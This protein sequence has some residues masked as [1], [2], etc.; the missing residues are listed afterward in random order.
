[1]NK[2]RFMAFLGLASLQSILNLAQAQTVP[3]DAGQLLNEQRRSLPPATPERKERLVD[4]PLPE[5]QDEVGFR[6]RIERVRFSG[7]QGLVEDEALQ[8]LVADAK[9]RELSHAQMRALA[10][11]VGAALQSRGYLL[12]RAY[13]PSQ[14]LSDGEL[15][16]AILAGRLQSSPGRVQ[17]LT[18]DP[19]LGRRLGAIADA[20]LPEGPVRNDQLE[21][22]LLLINDVPGVQA[23]A[24][25][26][27]GAEPGTSRMLVRAERAR[28]WAAG[29][30]VD[31]F[32]NRYTGQWRRSAWASLNRPLDREDLLGVN[33]SHS[34][35][36]RLLG[37]NYSLGLSPKGWRANM[38]ASWMD[39]EVGGEFKPL[40]LTGSARTFSAGLSYPLLRSR[41]RNL[42]FSVDAEHRQLTDKALGQTLRDRR[43]DKFTTMLSG[44][45][46]DQWLGGGYNGMN[47]GL[48]AGRLDLDNEIDRQVD[49]ASAR[50]AGSFAK[51][52]WRVERSQSLPNLHDWGVYL[53]AS[54]QIGS[55][56]LDSSEKFLLGGPAGVRGHTV[57]EASGDTGWLLNAELRRDF[58][59]ADG[60]RGQALAFADHGHVRQHID[61]WV[62]SS[63]PWAGNEYGLS[64]A[65]LGL[66]LH[67]ERWSL[68]SA[69]AHR[70]G[71]N[72]GRS[73]T[74]TNADGRKRD[75]YL[76]L[77]LSVRI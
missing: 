68:R 24:T 72:P 13:L 10:Q 42:W 14:D 61:P 64:G 47:V 76:W 37:L 75:Q 33:V 43:V 20:A 46:W 52:L 21:R 15:E 67:S 7:A 41:E 73:A 35:G 50:T 23:R 53:A 8:A 66:N 59:I 19:A 4:A 45:A 62:G 54:G 3:P 6:A 18:S 22:A 44:N 71:D 56:N 60:L 5:A 25:L 63:T 40:D 17:V 51:L 55:K 27:K 34:D 2:T 69:W 49:A 1:M 9:G 31:N 36:S 57:G 77:Q 74:G 29:A 11:R 48:V 65:G 38:A 30:A 70:L 39:Y 58:R 12:A 28:D 26:E 16:I 32:S